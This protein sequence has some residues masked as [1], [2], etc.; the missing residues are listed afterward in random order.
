[1]SKHF[2][3]MYVGLLT[4]VVVVLTIVGPAVPAD[5]ADEG[6]VAHFGR[7]VN[8]EEAAQDTT[9][10]VQPSTDWGTVATSVWSIGAC[11]AGARDATHTYQVLNCG[12]VEAI[13]SVT[14]TAVG[15]P[16]HLPTG[17]LITSVRVNYFDNVVGTEPS[18]GFYQ[19]GPTGAL[20]SVLPT[21]F[22]VFSGGNNTVTFVLGTPHQVVNSTNSYQWL[23]ILGRTATT[24]TGVNSFEV[25]Y[26]LQVSPAPATATFSDVPVGSGQHRFVEALAAAG[27]TGGCGAGL[28]CPNDPLT[29]GQMAVFL[30]V[31]LGLHF[32]N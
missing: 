12:R 27:I 30:S 18:I 24:T 8:P 20:I 2:R 15:F 19:V 11:G 14:S 10:G 6:R 28:Y 25:F 1:M 23:V 16:V 13:A 26:R 7:W 4:A 17:A 31:A 32:P 22:P 29:R 9:P 21:V 5:A 3:D